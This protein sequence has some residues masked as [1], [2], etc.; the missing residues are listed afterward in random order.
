METNRLQPLDVVDAKDRDIDRLTHVEDT[1]ATRTSVSALSYPEEFRM[2]MAYPA[3]SPVHVT[4]FFQ[5]LPDIDV[6]SAMSDLSLTEH[7]AHKDLTEVRKLEM[8]LLSELSNSFEEDTNAW[9]LNL[10]ALMYPGRDPH[11]G[12]I[13]LFEVGNNKLV[14]FIVNGV[15]PTTYRQGSYF[16][17][18]AHSSK[19][20]TAQSVEMLR[21]CV[22]DVFYFDKYKYFDD[23]RITLIKHQS[24]IDLRRLQQYRKE[25]IEA[26]MNRFYREEYE[27]VM[28][29]DDVYDPYLVEYLKCKIALSDY[30]RRPEQIDTQFGDGFYH[31][32]WSKMISQVATDVWDDIFTEFTV[33]S[34]EVNP[35]SPTNNA[36]DKTAFITLVEGSTIG[37]FGINSS[38]GTSGN[39][40]SGTGTTGSSSSDGCGLHTFD[41]LGRPTDC[42]TWWYYC[43]W[44]QLFDT[45]AIIRAIDSLLTPIQNVWPAI[46]GK[47]NYPDW[48]LPPWHKPP[49]H[50]GM[51]PP[52]G[53]HPRPPHHHH[54]PVRECDTVISK[55]VDNKTLFRIMKDQDKCPCHHPCDIHE[56][57]L[58]Y[59]KGLN[60][61]QLEALLKDRPDCPY[62]EAKYVLHDYHESELHPELEA[63][64]H[65]EPH[66][67]HG[68]HVH[69][70]D[71]HCQHFQPEFD[72][73][74]DCCHGEHHHHSCQ[75]DHPCHAPQNTPDVTC[76]TCT[77]CGHT[78]TVCK[79]VKNPCNCGEYIPHHPPCDYRQLLQAFS[80]YMKDA[81]KC[82]CARRRQKS[83]SGYSTGKNMSYVFS[84][85]FYLGEKSQM[86]PFEL[87]MYKYLHREDIPTAEVLEVVGSYRKLSDTQKYYKIP[88]LLAVID[89]AIVE[90]V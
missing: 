53:P 64:F 17:I 59:T 77:T 68:D 27:T 3:G 89:Y 71:E 25:L 2:L 72:F 29:V 63:V 1:F 39:T 4:Y 66:H 5:N 81:L 9:T 42:K 76:T 62:H 33:T 30:P 36:L 88:A 21:N 50:G 79:P 18:T 83:T 60:V 34:R 38:G 56:H 52:H 43:G 82:D 23:G 31:S 75:P 37:D 80:M 57:D 55:D 41:I 28:G 45:C 51:K 74:D 24:Y 40:G 85:Y 7:H 49:H 16:R 70:G 61:A 35:L 13:F 32:I 26:Y 14:E 58:V 69:V 84:P 15:T 87:I 10:E 90:L 67:H 78:Q 44:C 46:P 8:R 11:S 6:Q 22:H 12:D 19:F 48:L 65:G 47:P 20:A 86:D 73:E 54:R